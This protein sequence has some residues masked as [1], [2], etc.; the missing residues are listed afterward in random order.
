MWN[1]A[2][3][4][5]SKIRDIT[6]S[7]G[8][9]F[10]LSLQLNSSTALIEK[11]LRDSTLYVLTNLYQIEK[12]DDVNL[13]RGDWLERLSDVVQ[14]RIKLLQNPS[15][16]TRANILV[17]RTSCLCGYGCQMHYY[18]FCLNMAYATGRTLIS[19]RQKTHCEKWWA[20]SYM[21][22]SDRCSMDDIGR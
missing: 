15:D 13:C 5:L 3:A 19:D 9:L 17:A 12:L 4:N 1:V 20:E 6:K 22:F 18:M 11:F 10:Q 16:C 21:P 2:F 7:S 14:T 8:T